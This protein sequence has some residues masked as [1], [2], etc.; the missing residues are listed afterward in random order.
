M[1]MVHAVPEVQKRLHPRI[2]ALISTMPMAWDPQVAPKSDQERLEDESHKVLV[3]D[4]P[5]S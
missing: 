5:P 3:T 2:P 4:Q 1:V